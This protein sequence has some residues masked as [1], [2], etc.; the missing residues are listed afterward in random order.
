MI[1]NRDSMDVKR[2]HHIRGGAIYRA[3]RNIALIIFQNVAETDNRTGSGIAKLPRSR[4]TSR[5]AP[6]GA[7]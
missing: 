1:A 5:D 2:R 4:R 7:V 6:I 3:K